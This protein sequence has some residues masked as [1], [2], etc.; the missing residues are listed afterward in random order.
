MDDAFAM[1]CYVESFFLEGFEFAVGCANDDGHVCGFHDTEL[2]FKTFVFDFI[3]R[4]WLEVRLDGIGAACITD[5]S[6][7]IDQNHIFSTVLLKLLF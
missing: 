6:S 2:T 5:A 4:G 1:R 3:H 7:C